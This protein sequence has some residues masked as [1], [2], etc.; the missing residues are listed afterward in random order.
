[1]LGVANDCY[2]IEKMVP[3]KVSYKSIWLQ[4]YKVYSDKEKYVT[5]LEFQ[6]DLH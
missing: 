1:M 3:Y 4:Y 5:L 2:K 6:C